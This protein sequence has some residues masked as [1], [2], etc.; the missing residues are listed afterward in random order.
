MGTVGKLVCQHGSHA[1]LSL[2]LRGTVVT[3]DKSDNLG[4]EGTI[5]CCMGAKDYD[6]TNIAF[7][8]TTCEK[9]Y[10][11]GRSHLGIL[12]AD[13]DYFFQVFLKRG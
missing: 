9:V 7:L 4:D 3:N 11:E 6:S 13:R 12:L 1:E 5:A 8:N 10:I 2:S